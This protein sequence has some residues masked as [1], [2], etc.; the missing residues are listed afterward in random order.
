MLVLQGLVFWQGW[1]LMVPDVTVSVLTIALEAEHHQQCPQPVQQ[2][3][4]LVTRHIPQ[5]SDGSHLRLLIV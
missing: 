4:S 1:S 3:P 5:A 2:H